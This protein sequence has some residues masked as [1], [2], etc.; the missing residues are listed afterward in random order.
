MGSQSS[1]RVTATMWRATPYQEASLL[2]GRASGAREAV[3]HRRR[4]RDQADDVEHV[5]SHGKATRGFRPPPTH[6][7]RRQPASSRPMR[8]SAP[9]PFAGTMAVRDEEEPTMVESNVTVG[10]SAGGEVSET[11]G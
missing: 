5:C 7:S 4:P 8:V 2:G 10:T 3:G 11:G 1:L 9:V 6:T